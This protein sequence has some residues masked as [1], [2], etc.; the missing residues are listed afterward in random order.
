[1]ENAYFVCF[2]AFLKKENVPYFINDFAS[3]RPIC[4][5]EGRLSILAQPTSAYFGILLC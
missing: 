1:M 5:A 4:S 2:V 3:Q